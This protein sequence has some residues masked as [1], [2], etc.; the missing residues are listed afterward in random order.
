M[1]SLD[2]VKAMNNQ[3][4]F[5]NPRNNEKDSSKAGRKSQATK[6]IQEIERLI[7]AHPEKYGAKELCKILDVSN[8]TIVRDV[9]AIHWLEK[10]RQGKYYHPVFHKIK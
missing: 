10:T 6:R 7:V 3:D 5:T 4:N 1:M 9:K 8:C 2:N